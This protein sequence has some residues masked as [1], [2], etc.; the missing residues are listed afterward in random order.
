[1][2]PMKCRSTGFS[3]KALDI[4]LKLV[5]KAN[6]QIRE[7]SMVFIVLNIYPRD[8]TFTSRLFFKRESA[9]WFG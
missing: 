9:S 8:T 6:Q 7:C 5:T 3:A 4:G 1:M 2:P